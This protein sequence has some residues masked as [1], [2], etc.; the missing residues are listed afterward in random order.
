VKLVI[1]DRDQEPRARPYGDVVHVWRIESGVGR[2]PTRGDVAGIL[3][4]YRCGPGAGEI[5]GTGGK[6]MYVCARRAT[7]LRHNVSHSAGLS[8]LVVAWEREVGVD[9]EV[10]RA[11]PWHALRHQA[12]TKDELA[13][14]ERL[15]AAA[16]GRAF[17]T[18]WVRKEAVLKCAGV[19][20]TVE[21][22]LV[23]VGSPFAPPRLGPLPFR[24]KAA[25]ALWLRDLHLPGYAAAVA[26][27]S[28]PGPLRRHVGDREMRSV[29]GAMRSARHLAPGR[30]ERVAVHTP[31]T[32]DDGGST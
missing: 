26:L 16:Q 1:L 13:D 18:C 27:D 14:V 29:R 8:L 20:L 15:P 31:T 5:L 28:A 6:P 3:D 7:G 21:P 12:L 2:P 23:P 17:L 30:I 32:T 11:G 19:G 4:R 25:P 24:G 10:V 22:G 9:V